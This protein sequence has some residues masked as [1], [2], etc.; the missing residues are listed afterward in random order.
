MFYLSKPIC[1]T[2]NLAL[3][4]VYI[5]VSSAECLNLHFLL[6][7]SPSESIDELKSL[8]VIPKMPK[9]RKTYS[10]SAML[11]ALAELH[12]GK[13]YRVVSDKCTEFQ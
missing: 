3:K 7:N 6:L 11:Q 9:A 10:E 5:K 2:D 12:E 1:L 4:Y 13:S 8:V